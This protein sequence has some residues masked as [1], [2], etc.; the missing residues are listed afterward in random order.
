MGAG[1]DISGG[2]A[3]GDGEDCGDEFGRD[4]RRIDLSSLMM[5]GVNDAVGP[6]ALG[7]G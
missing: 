4:D 6:L 2:T 1:T 5:D 3:C 7:L